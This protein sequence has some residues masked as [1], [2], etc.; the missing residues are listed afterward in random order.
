MI[1]RRSR[2]LG[3]RP[4][5]AAV[6]AGLAA[7]GTPIVKE[8]PAQAQERAIPRTHQGYFV[9]KGGRFIPRGQGFDAT[10]AEF[11]E[12]PLEAPEYVE[13]FCDTDKIS[14]LPGDEV[15]F[16]TSTT[17]KTFSIEILRQLRR[18]LS[19][20]TV[21][22]R[23]AAHHPATILPRHHLVTGGIAKKAAPFPDRSQLDPGIPGHRVRVHPRLQQVVL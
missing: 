12:A 21:Y 6:A 18:I 7:M 9:S 20:G 16:H 11:Y 5:P 1:S 15:R 19:S 22:L 17:A 4:W 14:Y 23:S 8:A 2:S 13:V 10:T 3:V